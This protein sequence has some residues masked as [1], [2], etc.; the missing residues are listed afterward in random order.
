LSIFIRGEQVAAQ[1]E[2]QEADRT[3]KNNVRKSA[4]VTRT[5]IFE[6]NETNKKHS[7]GIVGLES[8]VR[9]TIPFIVTLRY[10]QTADRNCEPLPI[11]EDVYEGVLERRRLSS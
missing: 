9:T 1:D 2:P 6:T 4:A 10:A 5:I 8:V 7:R 3:D 11:L